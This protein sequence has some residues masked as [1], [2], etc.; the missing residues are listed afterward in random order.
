[1]KTSTLLLAPLFALA[2]FA[3]QAQVTAPAPAAA[4]ASAPEPAPSP[5]TGNI[6]VTTNY[7]F[8]GQDQG[9]TKYFSPGV[10][11]GFDWSSNGW[12]LGNWNSNVSFGGNI[13]M[14]FYGG[15][16]GE[17]VKD[18]GYDVGVLEYYYP[19]KGGVDFNVTEIYGALSYSFFTFK[20]SHTVSKD[21]FGLGEIAS[22]PTFTPRGRN[23][24]Y[25]DLSGN[26]PLVDKLTL[27][28]HV[29]Y[30]HLS[31]DLRDA[32]YPSFYD[33][34]IGL[35]YDI[36]SGFTAAGAVIGASKKSYYGDYNKTRVVATISKAL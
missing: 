14:D 5:F 16:K 30:T 8:R 28:T 20:Y 13:E 34:K 27:N 25:L 26:F 4:P 24:G 11:G 1:M 10:Q 33:Y 29:G 23:T 31:S 35:T 32:S 22:T 2:A 12:Y 9:T 21:Y 18:L 17:I 6:N 15:Y 36:G 19:K 7:K 3:A